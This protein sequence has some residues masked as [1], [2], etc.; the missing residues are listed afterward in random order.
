[1]LEGT[2][3]AFN[4]SRNVS[5]GRSLDQHWSPASWVSGSANPGDPS[6]RLPNK[7]GPTWPNLTQWGSMVLL[8]MVSWIPSIYSSHVSIY[9][10][11]IHDPNRNANDTNE[12]KTIQI[13][14]EKKIV[15]QETSRNRGILVVQR[16]GLWGAHWNLKFDG[17][18]I[19]A[20]A[21]WPLARIESHGQ[22]HQFQQ[23]QS[24]LALDR[25]GRAFQ[26]RQIMLSYSSLSAIPTTL[27]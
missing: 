25:S 14:G 2:G 1:M 19:R 10:Y 20:T 3:Y 18:W 22:C 24:E 21:L 26:I 17:L 12:H 6:V 9:I 7:M 4:I 16:L 13:R 5:S 8:Y 11:T 23:L 27:W 15:S